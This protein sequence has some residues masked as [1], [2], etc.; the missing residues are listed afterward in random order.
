MFRLFPASEIDRHIVSHRTKTS[1]RVCGLSEGR[2][3]I[4]RES[5]RSRVHGA[6]YLFDDTAETDTVSLLHQ[7]KLQRP[8]LTGNALDRLAQADRVETERDTIWR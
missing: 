8:G 6:A 3:A 5:R 7:L 2:R 4:Q 1:V